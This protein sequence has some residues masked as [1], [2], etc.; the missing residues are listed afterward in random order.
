MATEL[1]P[2]PTR[3]A[4]LR[5]IADPAVEVYRKRDLDSDAIKSYCGFRVVTAMIAEFERAGWVRL[6]PAD[7]PSIY[8]RRPWELT[9]LGRQV[10]AA[11]DSKEK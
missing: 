9:D 2:T 1:H 11:A 10:L 8:A 3:L 6:G 4:L 5:D 7:H